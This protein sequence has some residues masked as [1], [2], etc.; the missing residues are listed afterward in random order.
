MKPAIA[1]QV[2]QKAL[3]MHF[4]YYNHRY[5]ILRVFDILPNFPFATSEWNLIINNKLVYTSCLTRYR[6]T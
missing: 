4:Q 2:F 3:S 1:R 5:N 6:M